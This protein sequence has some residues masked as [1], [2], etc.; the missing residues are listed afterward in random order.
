MEENQQKSIS[1]PYGKEIDG[2]GTQC[3]LAESWIDDDSETDFYVENVPTDWNDEILRAHFS[4]IC[5]IIWARLEKNDKTEKPSRIGYVKFV[6]MEESRK[7]VSHINVED[8]S[9]SGLQLRLKLAYCEEH[10]MKKKSQEKE[11]W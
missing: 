1:G 11:S 2:R 9:Q 8:Y 3:S 6:N 7:A 4:T 10:K 5:K